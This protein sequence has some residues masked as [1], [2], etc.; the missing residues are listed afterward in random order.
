MRP[1]LPRMTDQNGISRREFLVASATGLFALSRDW[2]NIGWSAEGD[3]QLLYVGTYTVGTPSAGVYILRMD[4]RTGQ[5]R[6]VGTVDVGPNPSYLAIHP[7]G[8]VLYAVNEVEKFNGVSGGGVSAFAI[9]SASGALTHR[10][11]QSSGGAGPCYVSLDRSGRLVLVADY[12]AGRIAVLP[13]RRDG[14]LAPATQ[15][16]HHVGSG[17][18][19]DRQADPH[20]HCIVAD[21]SN[22]FVL[23]ADLGADRVF[24]YRLHV[25]AKS[26]TRVEGGEAVMRPG[27]GPRHIVFHP[28]LPVVYV[29]NELA[30]TVSTLRFDPARG[31]LTLLDNRST[32]P[33]GWNGKNDTADIH[34]SRSGR[35]VY[36]SNRGHNSIAVL[37]V[38]KSTG[39]LTLDQIVSTEGAT[40]RN[41]SLDPTGRW[42]LAANQDSNSIVVFSRDEE[43]GRLTPTQQ[44]IA[45]PSPVC[46][47]FRNHGS[48]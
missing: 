35:N 6:Q 13:V 19:K 41:F 3:G 44:R 31:R 18:V 29:A 40:P 39:A 32:L 46:V 27:S 15:V 45:V 20:A 11:S 43:S 8:Q 1:G 48:N 2:W 26:L 37:S 34:I 4:P 16:I 12:D 25:G 21:P 33:A 14:S 47:R 42:L 23:A 5:L 30:S 7:N 10:N 24:V 36:V 28:A 17:P 22:R 9:A 38:A